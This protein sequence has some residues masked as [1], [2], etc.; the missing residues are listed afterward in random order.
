MYCSQCG[1]PLDNGTCPN[2]GGRG[3]GPVAVTLRIPTLGE[4]RPQPADP[5]S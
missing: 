2:C 5:T 1:T 3:P 4:R